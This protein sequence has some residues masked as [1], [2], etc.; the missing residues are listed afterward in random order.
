MH[1]VHRTEFFHEGRGPELLSVHLAKGSSHL[2]AIDFRNPD[3]TQV[4]HLKF[5]QAQ[6]YMFTPEEVENYARTSVDWGATD[7][8]SLVS[9]GRSSWLESF[10][11]RHLARCSHFRVMF[12]DEF[13]DVLCENVNVFDGAY[14][15]GL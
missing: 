3:S 8:G 1:V 14:A 15:S 7:G 4:R 13:L 11:P 12:Y 5:Q 10:S 6:A 9:L 2:L